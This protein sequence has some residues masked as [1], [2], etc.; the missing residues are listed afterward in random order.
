MTCQINKG[1]VVVVVVVVAFFKMSFAQAKFIVCASKRGKRQT[2]VTNSWSLQATQTPLLWKRFWRHVRAANRVWGRPNGKVR[3]TRKMVRDGAAGVHEVRWTGR[4]G[5]GCRRQLEGKEEELKCCIT[6]SCLDFCGRGLGS[7]T[8][9][10]KQPERLRHTR[11]TVWGSIPILFLPSPLPRGVHQR[12]PARFQESLSAGG[13]AVWLILLS[14]R[15]RIHRQR[16]VHKNDF[17]VIQD[18]TDTSPKT[19]VPWN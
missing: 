17:P 3:L 8:S 2:Q 16:S 19:N 10:V 9:A 7:A 4:T 6:E 11:S 5:A 13:G 12:L 18:H 14:C 1:P 15:C